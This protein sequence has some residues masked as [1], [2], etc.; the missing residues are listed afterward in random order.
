MAVTLIR[1]STQ[2]LDGSIP[3]VKMAPGT[4]VPSSSLVDGANFLKKDG[5]VAMT[6]SFNAGGFPITSVGNP[7]LPLD[8]VNLQTLQTF[9]NGF[10]SS[11]RARVINTANSALSGLQTVDGKVLVAGDIV[12]DNAQTTASQN[13]LWVVAAG[14]WTR[15]ANWAAASIQKSFQLFIEEG[16]LNADTKWTVAADAVVVDTTPVTAVQDTT[17][18]TY[19][20]DNTKGMLLTGSAFSV[21]LAAAG[22][23][24]FD[25]TG[26]VQ[27]LAN[28]AS[29]NVSAAG[30]KVADGVA[31]QL[32]IANPGATFTTLSGDA[33]LSGAGALTLTT[34]A[35][36]VVKAANVVLND[37]PAGA[38]NGVNA[39]FT[40][41]AA[42]LLGKQTVYLNGERLNPGAGN[43]Y[44]IAG[45][46]ITM[47]NI[48]QTGDV[49][50]SDYLK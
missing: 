13:G 12:W 2:I 42:P 43:D 22:G 35:A 27:V 34:G 23:L 39:V 37:L 36:G 50:I 48:P 1:G 46:T 24:N 47:L 31:G 14:A 3:W 16:T 19:T 10:G 9:V 15:P 28:G 26:N 45:A 44:T 5:S 40:L 4:I 20:A 11:K 25:G 49:L 33:T 38:I 6:A 18:N 30:V 32:M 8:A 29:L 41:A 7:F 21:K 17:G